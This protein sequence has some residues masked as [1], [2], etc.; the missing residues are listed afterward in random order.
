MFDLNISSRK[1]ILALLYAEGKAGEKEPIEGITRMEKL[2]FLLTNEDFK[3]VFGELNYKADNYGPFS[4][5]LVDQLENLVDLKLIE[6]SKGRN[7]ELA[8]EFN[9]NFTD[10]KIPDKFSLTF[11]GEALAKKIFT[12]LTDEE[13]KKFI[14]IKEKFNSIP[15]DALLSYIYN[16]VPS[17]YL[18]NS[19]IKEKY[20]KY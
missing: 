14:D 8:D 18:K 17:K 15:L 13:R 12:D 20:L 3:E 2:V 4:D 1:L 16:T 9:Y 11:Y 19:R 10:V 5:R 6:K 7:L